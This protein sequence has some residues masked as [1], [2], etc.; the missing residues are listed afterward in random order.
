MS[1]ST[2]GFSFLFIF[3]LAWDDTQKSRWLLLYNWTLRFRVGSSESVVSLEW[4]INQWHDHNNATYFLLWQQKTAVT[5]LSLFLKSCHSG[6]QVSA[7]PVRNAFTNTHR[8]GFSIY[9]IVSYAK[10][11]LFV[12]VSFRS[13]SSGVRVEL[14][15]CGWGCQARPVPQQRVKVSSRSTMRA[16][17][18]WQ[19]TSGW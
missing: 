13:V 2:L 6:W 18:R 4:N 15:G 12:H 3:S 9:K 1:L 16:R 11:E 14:L 7:L 5:S 8:C 10:L 17:L 19:L